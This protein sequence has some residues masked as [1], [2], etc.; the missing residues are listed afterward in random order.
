[1]GLSKHD[2]LNADDKAVHWVD[3]PEWGGQVG[4]REMTGAERDQFE[5]VAD[6]YSK[7]KP[8]GANLASHLLCLT[9]CDESGDRLFTAEDVEAL[10]A[11]NGNIIYRLSMKAAEISSIDD[12]ALTE[13]SDELKNGRAS[14]CGTV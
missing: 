1:M 8:S 14:S 4:L 11:K 12:N 13:A 5:R 9:L 10:A 2:I 7:G 3:V 6:D